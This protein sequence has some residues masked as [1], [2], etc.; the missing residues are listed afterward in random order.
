MESINR[1]KY[2]L[3]KA[4]LQSVESVY[5]GGGPY[6]A[7]IVK[8]GEIIAEAGN[9]VTNDHDPTAHAEVNAIRIASKKLKTFD[10]SECEIFCSCEP[11]PMCLGAIYWARIDKIFYANTS[12]TAKEYG[13]DDSFIYEEC[14][15]NSEARKIPFEHIH[16]NNSLDAFNAWREKQDKEE[17]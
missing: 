2:F 5:Q 12:D 15:R 4:T 7:V 1:N 9:T 16:V 10:L 6:G 14:S 11:C 13:F 3:K 17:Y 8:D